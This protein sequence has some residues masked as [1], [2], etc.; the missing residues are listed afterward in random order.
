MFPNWSGWTGFVANKMPRAEMFSRIIKEHKATLQDTFMRD[1]LDVY[2]QEIR[3]TTNPSS[4]F[5]PKTGGKI[6]NLLAIAICTMY[7]RPQINDWH[8]FPLIH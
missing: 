8:M 4:T 7:L 3:K 5:H 1:F 2:L 6:N